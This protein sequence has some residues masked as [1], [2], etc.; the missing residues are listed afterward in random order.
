MHSTF[1]P[2]FSNEFFRGFYAPGDKLKKGATLL[3]A[4]LSRLVDVLRARRYDVVVVQRE[5]AI[6]GPPFFELLTHY[7][8]G[9][10][11]VFD[12]DDAIFIPTHQTQQTSVHGV[13]ARLLKD[14]HKADRIARIADE[15]IVANDF[16]ADW[17]RT[18][19]ERVTVIP[20]VVDPKIFRPM[21]NKANP[22]PVLGWIGSHSAAPQ[23]QVVLPALER[24]AKQHAFEVKLVGA[25]KDFHIPGVKVHNVPWSLQT[26]VD[27][28]RGLDIGLCP[29]FEDQWSKGKPGFKPMIYMGCG[30]P[31]VSTPLGGVTH[32]LKD[33]EAGFYARS[34]EEWEQ[35][36]GQLLSDPELRARMGAV[37]RERFLAGPT[38]VTQ[39]PVLQEVL[40]R[41]AARPR[42]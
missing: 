5:A 34:T 36:L 20:T 17:A 28:F 29:L 35:R 23:L 10:P 25:G 11:V 32:Y 26:E 4:A 16:A 9:V 37:G 8:A 30:V 40:L 39:T 33:G 3:Q 2:F 22:V 42:A 27:D 6:V 1:A 7:A 21:L 38:L 15:I 12:L 18:H 14:P 19:T 13:F 24:L 31:Q 41:A